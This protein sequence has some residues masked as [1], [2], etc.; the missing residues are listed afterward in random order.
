MKN[1][2]SQI[3][4]SLVVLIAI[5]LIIAVFYG[6][7]RITGAYIGVTETESSNPVKIIV[8]SLI[9][10]SYISFKLYFII[11]NN[12]KREFNK[13]KKKTM[14]FIEKEHHEKAFEHYDK[15]KEEFERFFK[16]K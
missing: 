11:K 16:N 3:I 9:I 2:V 10:L 14:E 7:A 1:T 15:L 4:N 8:L 5:F 13:L 12:S 6:S